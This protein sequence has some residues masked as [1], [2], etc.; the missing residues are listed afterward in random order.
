MAIFGAMLQPLRTFLNRP[1]AED[2]RFENQ[3]W[4]SLQGEGAHKRNG[5]ACFS[6]AKQFD[7]LGVKL[8]CFFVLG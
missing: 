8:L 4:Q 3:I 7:R 5:L 2:F 1:I 6:F